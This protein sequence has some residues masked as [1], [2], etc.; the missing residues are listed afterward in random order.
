MRCIAAI[1]FMLSTG[2]TDELLIVWTVP[3]CWA[4]LALDFL[5]TIIEDSEISAEAAPFLFALA[6]D[7]DDM[8]L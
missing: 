3:A 5:R 7:E 2:L 4:F 8:S 6:L 1:S